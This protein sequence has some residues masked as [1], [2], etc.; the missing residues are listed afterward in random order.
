MEPQSC[1]DDFKLLSSRCRA[2]V[3]VCVCVCAVLMPSV[4]IPVLVC[5]AQREGV[6]TF[7]EARR[8]MFPPA[9]TAWWR[10]RSA[11]TRALV[12]GLSLP[13]AAKI[14]AIVFSR[15]PLWRI[16][17]IHEVVA[18]PFVAL[19]CVSAWISSYAL[20]RCWV[21]LIGWKELKVIT[22]LG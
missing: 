12:E 3:N 1:R 19:R 4:C 9:F 8:L 16:T 18:V 20:M 21:C 11:I 7:R 17:W 14:Q 6:W 5:A 2:C 10:E 22:L 13:S 15:V